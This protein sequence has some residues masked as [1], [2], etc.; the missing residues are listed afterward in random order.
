MNRLRDIQY[1]KGVGERS[2][3]AF[4]KLGIAT[5]G[6]LVMTFPRRYEDRRHLPRMADLRP[7]VAATIMGRV[8]RFENRRVGRGKVL[9][10]AVVSDGSGR[11]TLTWFNQPWIERTIA[12]ATQAKGRLVAY[13]MVRRGKDGLEIASPEW[14]AQGPDDDPQDFARIV[15]VYGLT[16]GLAQRTVR[17]A[18]AA[19]LALTE[20]E[21]PD[22]LPEPFRRDNG[23]PEL[24]WCLQQMHAPDEMLHQERA[25]ERLVY[26]EFLTMQ[27]EFAQRRAEN[28][29]ETG[30][31]FPIAQLELGGVREGLAG[32]FE[33]GRETVPLRDE[34]RAMLPFEL[35]GAQQRVVDEIWADMARPFPMNRLVQGDVGSG[36]TAVAACAILAAV[37]SGY[38]AALMAPTEILAEQH[39]VG[40]RRWLE[41]RGIEVAVLIGKQGAKERRRANQAAAAGTAGLV[42]GTHALVQ[43]AVKFHRLGLAIV[44]EQHRFG[45][46]QRKALRDKGFGNPDILVMTATPIP[47]T[48][49][50]T[51]YGHLDVS[52]IDE[53]PPGRRPVKTHWKPPEERDAVYAAVRKMIDQGRQAYVVC[54]L[55]SET[56]K[57]NAQ[58]A[59]DLYYRLAND[60]FPDLKVGLLHGQMKPVEKEAT[61]E[62]FRAGEMALLVST[63]VI[64]VGVDVPN[65]TV[66]VI[67]DAHRFG[68]SQLHQ[69]RGRVGRGGHQSYCILMAPGG[70]EDGNARL[71][72]MVESND[73]FR[74]AERDFELRGPGV[75][76]GTEQSGRAEFLI[77]DLL[78][79]SRLLET[80][81]ATAIRLVESDEW[82]R[83][84]W[85]LL[86]ERLGSHRGDLAV[87]SIS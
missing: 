54:P 6:D 75:I 34:V 37:R 56:E 11:V 72:I 79:D 26:E 36:K 46:L 15:P 61:M 21:W 31:A 32:L 80:A 16:E 25:R 87:T 18:A 52:V 27:L 38:Q 74:I 3:A 69:L 35:T 2:A 24:A 76:A 63:T 22:P 81:R 19:A 47:R 67:E 10:Q 66:M 12:P 44:D 55:V 28:H 45:V 83:P 5:A 40:M 7:G 43:E 73:G 1:V 17:R 30:I 62:A 86:R 70:G 50:L 42:V 49:A 78:R 85:D 71:E 82:S 57:L 60:V 77:A 23:L 48:L 58:A 51:R 59:E 64:E 8:Q 9:Q 29:T 39:A 20:G 65:A 68:L 84:E 13:G 14:E 4:R 33:V 41:P 53:L